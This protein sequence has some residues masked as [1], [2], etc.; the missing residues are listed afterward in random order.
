MCCGL[1]GPALGKKVWFDIFIKW[2]LVVLGCVKNKSTKCARFFGGV[3]Y[4][5]KE[6][7]VCL[8]F[9]GSMLFTW[10]GVFSW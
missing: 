8:G 10:W 2:F 6:N 1:F 5:V 4:K 9:L 7:P 3:N